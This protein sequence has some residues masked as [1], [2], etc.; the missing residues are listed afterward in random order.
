MSGYITLFRI[1]FISFCIYVIYRSGITCVYAWYH[2][3]I[4]RIFS[5]FR[6]P[7]PAPIING[8]HYFTSLELQKSFELSEDYFKTLI[9]PYSEKR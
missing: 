6:G 3:N 1:D 8:L 7:V 2:Y 4:P 9:G 5:D